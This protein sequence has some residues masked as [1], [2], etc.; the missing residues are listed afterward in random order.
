VSKPGSEHKEQVHDLEN[1]AI[2]Q[3]LE[4][5]AEHLIPSYSPFILSE[6]RAIA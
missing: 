5:V 4:E 3:Q 1:D 2:A 6:E